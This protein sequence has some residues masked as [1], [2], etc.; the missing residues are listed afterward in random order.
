MVHRHSAA[1]PVLVGSVEVANVPE[2]V[3]GGCGVAEH[4]ANGGKPF[5]V[6][7]VDDRNVFGGDCLGFAVK[8][9][10]P[11]VVYFLAALGIDL[12]D[13]GFPVRGRLRLIGMPQVQVTAAVPQVDAEVWFGAAAEPMTI[14]SQS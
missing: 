9:H 6:R 10:P 14:D 12:V 5:G 3:Q 4:V 8:L 13:C 2:A 11:G 1:P 7:G